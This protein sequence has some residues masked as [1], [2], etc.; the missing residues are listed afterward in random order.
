M[1][2]RLVCVLL[3]VAAVG[4][5]L[6]SCSAEPA[7]P[8]PAFPPRP[9]TLQ[10]DR[11]PACDLLSR[12]QQRELKLSQPASG[13]L[14]VEGLPTRTCTFLGDDDV[15]INV[16]V[17]PIDTAVALRL[18]SASTTQINGFGAVMNVPTERFGDGP[19]CQVAV[20]AAPG[21]SV[22]VQALTRTDP[23]PIPVDQVCRRATDV[24]SMV[25]TT[26]VAAAS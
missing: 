25:M 22:R 10:L 17:I 12:T 13:N 1:T 7:E 15:D 9:A 16:Q 6:V 4:A 8:P 11:L 21:Q 23:P 5:A 3:G 20:D 24:A 2:G 14:Q 18:P 19:I 26:V